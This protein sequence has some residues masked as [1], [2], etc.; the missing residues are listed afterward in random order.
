M[1]SIEVSLIYNIAISPVDVYQDN[2]RSNMYISQSRN[3][4]VNIDIKS[5]H[6]PQIQREQDHSICNT[7]SDPRE[8][9]VT[10]LILKSTA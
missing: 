9:R 10:S 4:A 1:R 8:Q 6:C 5:N 3:N 7:K 2:A